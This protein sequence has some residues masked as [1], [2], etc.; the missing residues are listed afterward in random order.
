[1]HHLNDLAPCGDPVRVAQGDEAML[2]RAVIDQA[3]ES[4]NLAA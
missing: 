1:M 2:K 4:K 3:P